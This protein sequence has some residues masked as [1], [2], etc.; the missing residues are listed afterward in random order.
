MFL[1]FKAQ[2]VNG[3]LQLK[4][5]FLSVS[6]LFALRLIHWYL[7]AHF[8]HFSSTVFF[9]IFFLYLFS[10]SCAFALDRAL[11]HFSPTL[12]GSGFVYWASAECLKLI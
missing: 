9:S 2:C 8:L 11:P 4:Y 3:L 6:S 12:L 10:L 5:T 1:A 7:K